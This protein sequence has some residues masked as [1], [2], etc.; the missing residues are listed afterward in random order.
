MEN[1]RKCKGGMKFKVGQRVLIS[2]NFSKLH[3]VSRVATVIIV[4]DKPREVFPYL[5]RLSNGFEVWFMERELVAC[6]RSAQ[7]I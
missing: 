1:D 7:V 4:D 6:Q 3:F 5:L 2:E